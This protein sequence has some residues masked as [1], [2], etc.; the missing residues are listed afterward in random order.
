MI[1]ATL[2][3][4]C[5]TGCAAVG[6]IV[7]GVERPDYKVVSSSDAIEIREYQPMIIAEVEVEGQRDD[8]IGDGFR[9]LAD[10]IFGNNIAQKDIAMTAPVQQ[11]SSEKIAMTA[12]VQQQ[13]FGD[14]WKVSFVMPSQY[15]IDTLPKPVNDKVTLKEVDAKRYIAITF[16]GMNSDTNITKYTGVLLQYIEDN[17][18]TT[19]GL[20]TYAFYNPPWT[21]PFMRRNEV[22][23]EMKE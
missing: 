6:V 18:I 11:Q 10:Y 9:L 17:T 3:V 4:V 23:I 5:L 8:A 19:T 13:S 16:S 22:M 7:N 14:N 15:T 12:P 1:I 21:L 20:P 2:C